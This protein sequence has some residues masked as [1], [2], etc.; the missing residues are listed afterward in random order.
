M[1]P[2]AC[3]SALPGGLDGVCFASGNAD[4]RGAA[5]RGDNTLIQGVQCDS[6]YNTEDGQLQ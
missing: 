1:V 3:V 2:C 6:M 5:I 4:D